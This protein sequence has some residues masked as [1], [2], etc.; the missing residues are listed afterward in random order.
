[1]QAP[2]LHDDEEQANHAGPPRDEEVLQVLQ[3]PHA[4]QGNK[5]T[6]ARKKGT[7]Q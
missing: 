5:I 2:Q 7:G 4:A 3:D 1:M 6:A